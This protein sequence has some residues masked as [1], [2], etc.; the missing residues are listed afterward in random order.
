MI[1]LIEPAILAHNML[2]FEPGDSIWGLLRNQHELYCTN[3]YSEDIPLLFVDYV[4]FSRT[5]PPANT[6]TRIWPLLN[7][8]YSRG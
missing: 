6:F 4:S 3:I 1:L 7:S 8:C 5:K 2:K